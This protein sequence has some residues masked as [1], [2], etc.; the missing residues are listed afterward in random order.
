ML[1][2]PGQI[3]CFRRSA[4]NQRLTG[5]IFEAAAE[6]DDQIDQPTNAKKACRQEPENT[7]AGLPY[8]E[9]VNAKTAKEEA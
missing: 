3:L 9:A 1:N 5:L 6:N 7:R 2:A 8:I 4:S